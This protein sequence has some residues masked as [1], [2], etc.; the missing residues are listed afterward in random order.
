MSWSDTAGLLLAHLKKG[1]IVNTSSTHPADRQQHLNLSWDDYEMVTWNRGTNQQQYLNCAIHHSCVCW[2]RHLKSMSLWEYSIWWCLGI[3]LSQCANWLMK[4]FCP[5]F[6]ESIHWQ[7]SDCI[8][9]G[10]GAGFSWR[11]FFP[12]VT[13]NA[14]VMVHP[15]RDMEEHIFVHFCIMTLT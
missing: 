2:A 8:L 1:Q 14:S 15:I 7:K 9:A 11:C 4:Y 13:K 10:G 12:C 6:H 3:H 5:L